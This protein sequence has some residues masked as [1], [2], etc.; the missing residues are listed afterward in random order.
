MESVTD[1]QTDASNSITKRLDA[2]RDWWRVYD[3]YIAAVDPKLLFQSER[4]ESAMN[5][6][7]EMRRMIHRYSPVFLQGYLYDQN[8][9]EIER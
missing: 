4:K 7:C 1:L 6:Y 5:Y 9:Q 2:R 8:G 3:C